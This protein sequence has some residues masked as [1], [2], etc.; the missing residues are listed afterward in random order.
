MR[1]EY[2]VPATGV[3]LYGHGT[4]SAFNWNPDC[5]EIANK[6]SIRRPTTRASWKVYGG[7]KA[8][9]ALHIIRPKEY[10]LLV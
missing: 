7:A 5:D 1:G 6:I 4:F 8:A 9:C 10:I 2:Y 3:D